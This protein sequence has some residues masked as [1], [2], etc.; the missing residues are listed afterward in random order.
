MRRRYRCRLAWRW[1]W[2]GGCGQRHNL[3]AL[4]A[5]RHKKKAPILPALSVSDIPPAAST[6]VQVRS[7]YCG[8]QIRSL[9]NH[10]LALRPEVLETLPEEARAQLGFKSKRQPHLVGLRFA[11]VVAGL[12]SGSRTAR[13]AGRCG[14]ATTRICTPQPTP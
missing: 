2:M 9:E 14:G 4:P 7:T 3:Y 11:D 8:P 12:Q 1:C 5:V 10:V 13:R 6:G